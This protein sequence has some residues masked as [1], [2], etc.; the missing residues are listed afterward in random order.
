MCIWC[1]HDI[2]ADYA[3]YEACPL[4]KVV[5]VILCMS[6]LMIFAMLSKDR[7]SF[8]C[9]GLVC[10]APL[11]GI[12]LTLHVRL[13]GAYAC[14]INGIVLHGCVLLIVLML[15]GPAGTARV[16]WIGPFIVRLFIGRH[17]PCSRSVRDL[18]RTRL[19]TAMDDSLRRL[20]SDRAMTEMAGLPLR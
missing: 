20:N 7:V 3:V 18:S 16:P 4:I 9:K 8:A 17:G 12:L 6:W 14:L 1:L 19:S 11:M 15:L 13:Q 10:A 5:I 2:E